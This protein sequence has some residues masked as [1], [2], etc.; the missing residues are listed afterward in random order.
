MHLLASDFCD[1]QE[2]SGKI[3]CR[4]F[5]LKIFVYQIG[6]VRGIPFGL[7]ASLRDFGACPSYEPTAEKFRYD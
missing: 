3:S 7:Q 1:E 5:P 6:G 4:A 2:R